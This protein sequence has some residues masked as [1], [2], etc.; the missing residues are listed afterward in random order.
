[1]SLK[2]ELNKDIGGVIKYQEDE[3]DIGVKGQRIAVIN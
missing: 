2:R 3:E 1:M